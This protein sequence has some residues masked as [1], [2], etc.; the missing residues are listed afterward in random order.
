MLD[1]DLAKKVMVNKYS[2]R[3]YVYQQLKENIVNLKLEPG[4]SISEKEIAEWLSVSRTP[5]REAFVRLNQEQLLEVYPQRGTVVSLIDLKHVDDA[6]FIREHLEVATVRV[7]CESFP[8]D[9][10]ALLEKN[11]ETQHRCVQEKD[12]EQLFELDEEFH[13]TIAIGSQKARV[14]SVIQQMNSHLNRVR[15]LSLASEFNWETILRQHSEVLNAIKA[16]DPE[17]AAT[18]MAQHLQ[19]VSVDQNELKKA[20]PSYFK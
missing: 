19:L 15:L 1:A 18:V 4:L 6:R 14:W 9:K 2:T 5:V 16:K 20:Y 10:T 17:R 8:E 13:S 12:Y 11:I 3:D 7:A